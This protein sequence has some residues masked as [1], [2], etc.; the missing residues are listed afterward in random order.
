MLTVHLRVNDEATGKPIPVRL[1]ITDDR[2]TCY[3]PLGRLADFATAP[4]VDVGGQV[5]LGG[6]SFAFIDG[7]CEARLPAGPLNIEAS[8]GFEYAPLE[9]RA[10]LGAGQMALR[11]ALARRTDWSKDGWFAGDMRAHDL[12]PHAAALEGAA[13][14]LAVVQL[15]ARERPPTPASP[16]AISNLPAFSGT[17][18]ALSAHGCHVVVNTSNHH[19]VLGSVSLLNSHRPVFPLRFGEP[20]EPDHW[21][22][23]DWCDQCH[24]KSGLV[25]WPDL[26]R[27]RAEQWQGEAL[28]A[29]VLG[30]IDAW[31]VGPVSDLR[32]DAL[33][34]Y[35]RLLE[36]GLR[37]VLVGGSGKDSN[38]A[39]LGAM[40]TYARLGE[41]ETLSPATWIEAVRAGRTFITTGPLISL[42][43][44]GQGP[45]SVL[46]VEPGE[47][48]SLKAEAQG[49]ARF[50]ELRVL[51]NGEVRAITTASG[52]RLSAAIETDLVCTESGWV[53]ATCHSS[54]RLIGGPC[55]FAHTSPVYLEVRD[56]QRVPAEQALAPLRE[57]LTATRAWA[58]GQARCETSR[59]RDHLL[60]VLDEARARLASPGR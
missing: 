26:P 58:Q 20:G 40:R 8:R 55:V 18:A 22:V 23:A 60:A 45:G 46:S 5:R 34:D 3:P 24:R 53:A 13:E 19:P 44:A 50:E 37:P 35:H 39:V 7:T 49:G 17:A 4:G 9:A 59:Q 51:V 29:L 57:V 42:S 41:G 27:L 14:G 56:R 47:R 52:N 21:S 6:K 38:A 32:A 1:R 2:G 10:V 48:V 15:L 25:V 31:E 33:T 36:A 28:A 11:F 12:S 54:D 43:V 16:A 30:K